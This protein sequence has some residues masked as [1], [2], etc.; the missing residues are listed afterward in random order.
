MKIDGRIASIALSCLLS[1]ACVAQAAAIGAAAASRTTSKTTA[2]AKVASAGA[3]ADGLSIDEYILAID[4][5]A[6]GTLRVGE[7]IVVRNAG[8]PAGAPGHRRAFEVI[9]P[10]DATLLRADVTPPGAQAPVAV[11]LQP[12]AEKGHFAFDYALGPDRNGAGTSFRLAFSVP[13]AGDSYTFHPQLTL[14]AARVWVALP[15]AMGFRG[16]AFRKV[17]DATVQTYLAV[18][19]PPAVA[20]E[21]TVS[22]VGVMP[23]TDQDTDQGTDQDTD[24]GTANQQQQSGGERDPLSRYKGWILCALG[25]GLVLVALFLL[26]RPAAASAAP[27]VGVATAHAHRERLQALK[28]ELFT[29]ETDKLAGRL[30]EAQYGVLKARLEQKLRTQPN[31]K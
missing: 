13:Y 30:T 21:F 9:L 12:E 24:Q 8:S 10:S 27:E 19:V 11:K 14:P 29:L 6:G 22:G 31:R 1:A 25:L 5:A 28:D 23:G 4:K 20:L 16:A 15:R 26:R 17:P 2:D 3:G 7:Q 18:T